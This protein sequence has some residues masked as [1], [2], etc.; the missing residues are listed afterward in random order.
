MVTVLFFTGRI[1]SLRV[2]EN[3]A[4]FDEIR[5]FPEDKAVRTLHR[6]SYNPLIAV[7]SKFVFPDE[8]LLHLGKMLRGV[9]SVN[10]FQCNVLA[11][12]IEALLQRTSSAFVCEGIENLRP[13]RTFLAISN[14]RDITLDAALTQLALCRHNM[15]LMEL[16]IGSNLMDDN[17][18]ASELLRSV[19]MI[20]VRRGLSAREAYA[21]S[22]LLSEYIRHSVAGGRSSI[23]IAQKE[24]RA[25]N[26]LDKTAHGIIKML[27]MSGMKGFYEN[28][29]ELV[30]TPMSISYEYEPCDISKARETLISST[31]RYIKKKGEDTRSI[32]DGI[33]MWKGGIHLSICRPLG[34]DELKMASACERAQR[35]QMVR[36]MIDGRIVEGYKLWKTNYIAYDILNGTE[37]Y[38]A[39]YSSSE[40]EAF[41]NYAERRLDSVEPELDRDELRRHFLSIYANP[42]VSKGRV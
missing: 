26:G 34:E 40:R 32:L 21:A 25:K 19:S 24:G 41:V 13:G 6:L 18:M 12:S 11:P 5:P 39:L 33:R 28:F 7:A 29:A 31:R 17:R 14:H 15:P 37:K 42:V 3:D 20:R 38:A 22:C 36:D 4:R 8:P 23:W 2:M 1:I 10:D 30:I 16:C 35:Y 9:K 27:D